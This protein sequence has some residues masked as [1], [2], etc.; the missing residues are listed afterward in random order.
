MK[1]AT[2]VSMIFIKY[3]GLNSILKEYFSSQ[4]F[5][6]SDSYMGLF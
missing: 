3:V 4:F 2:K 6:G 1:I 5:S